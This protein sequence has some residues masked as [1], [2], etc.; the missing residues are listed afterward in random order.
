MVHGLVEH[1]VYFV[2]NFRPLLATEEKRVQ[3]LF[4]S[5]DP[6]NNLAEVCK[7]FKVDFTM[8]PTILRKAV[9]TAAYDEL[10]DTERRKLAAHMTHRSE[11]QFRAYSAK[12]RREEATKTVQ[13]MKEVLYQTDDTEGA[14]VPGPSGAHELHSV[15][16][17][18]QF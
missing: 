13:K 15:Q 1:L 10:S 6:A 2:E 11:T 16:M 9:S 5:S 8:T 12:N 14:S 7:S 3:Y 4:P 18:K 17:K